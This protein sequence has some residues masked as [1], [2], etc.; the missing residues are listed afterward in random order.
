MGRSDDYVPAR[1]Y[2]RTG[3]VIGW[4]GNIRGGVSDAKR[5]R[6]QGKTV[7]IFVAA[8]LEFGAFE[9]VRVPVTD[10][11]GFSP[12]DR[13]TLTTVKVELSFLVQS[14]RDALGRIGDLEKTRLTSRDLEELMSDTDTLRVEKKELEKRVTAIERWQWQVV[15][16]SAAVGALGGLIV[17]LLLK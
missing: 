11:G 6:F 8:V 14:M 13:E 1:D 15:G 16:A 9:G 17:K 2:G 3:L 4:C 7:G 10:N 5:P 12:T